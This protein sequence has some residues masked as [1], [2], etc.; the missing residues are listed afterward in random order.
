MPKFFFSPVHNLSDP[1]CFFLLFILRNLLLY[2]IA[3]LIVGLS[4][5]IIRQRWLGLDASI[6]CGAPCSSHS[7]T[8]VFKED[9]FVMSFFFSLLHNIFI[10]L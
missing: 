4:G 2:S 10:L 5:L 9:F 1:T 8:Q 6:V 3:M 7:S